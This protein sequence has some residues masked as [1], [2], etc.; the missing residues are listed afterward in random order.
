MM[1]M[2]MVTLNKVS[3]SPSGPARRKKLCMQNTDN[4]V[5]VATAFVI[6]ANEDDYII[7][8]N[9]LAC[10]HLCVEVCLSTRSR[11]LIQAA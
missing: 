6:G 7:I 3:L 1:M 10:A 5:D 2:T 4:D 9:G 8:L 11:S